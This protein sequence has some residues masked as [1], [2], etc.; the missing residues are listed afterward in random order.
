MFRMQLRR[1]DVVAAALVLAAGACARDTTA[2][3]TRPASLTPAS[4]TINVPEFS[5]A[6]TAAEEFSVSLATDGTNAFVSYVSDGRPRAKLVSTAGTVLAS[7][8]ISRFGEVPLAAYDGTNFLFA[9][10]DHTDTLARVW[11]QFVNRSGVAVGGPLRLSQTAHVA[12]VF[13]LA[14]GGTK[15]LLMYRTDGGAMMGRF[16]FPN[17]TFGATFTI[18]SST[19]EIGLSNLAS[20]GTD[21][22][23][24]FTNANVTAVYARLIHADGS[25][26][27]KFLI[28]DSQIAAS[29]IGVAYTSGYY[30]V[31][32]NK[33]LT[34]KIANPR[35]QL[36][37]QGGLPHLGNIVV[38]SRTQWE[39][40]ATPIPVGGH[41]FVGYL[42]QMA[43]RNDATF[44][45]N[46]YNTGIVG[47]E[48]PY[49]V[50]DV[51]TA[52][53]PI[54]FGVKIGTRMFFVVNRATLGADPR[55]LSDLSGRD[56]HAVIVTP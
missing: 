26:P 49:F 42:K 28:S 31:T 34:D 1:G 40:V 51:A 54:P 12:D 35:A 15:Y 37:S 18:A 29:V 3:D 33:W 19:G 41:F 23:A 50:T 43:S 25:M 21:Y 7:L 45:R 47:A 44:A 8:S 24:T 2:P 5:L 16:V 36:V 53:I 38:D 39:T 14:W 52:K 55:S 22:L 11:G 48:K 56:V 6:S 30:L 20:D 17:K 4:L 46:I 27:P 9:W 13:G 32:W 10:V